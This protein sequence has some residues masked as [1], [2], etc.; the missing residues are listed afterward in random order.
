[1][2]DLSGARFGRLKAISVAGRDAYG[3]IRWSCQCDC[4]GLLTVFAHS[5]RSGDTQSCGCLQKESVVARSVRHGKFGTKVYSAWNGMRFRCQN[6]RAQNWARYGGR[7]IAV[8]ERWQTFENFYADMGDPPPGT[9]LDRID[10]DGNYEPG[11]VR[12]AT[13]TVQQRNLRRSVLVEFNGQSKTLPDWAEEIGI[14]SDAMLMRFKRGEQPPLLFRPA[15]MR[16]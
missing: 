16:A 12:W 1:M 4:G 5:L 10:V 11:N 8:C 13:A 15:G 7:G 9:S 14:S 2:M 3:A 6:P